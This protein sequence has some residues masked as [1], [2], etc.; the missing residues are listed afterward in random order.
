[1][2]LCVAVVHGGVPRIAQFGNALA[3]GYEGG[4]RRHAAHEPVINPGGAGPREE[5]FEIHAP[6]IPILRERL[7]ARRQRARGGAL[8]RGACGLA[9]AYR[10]VEPGGQI[11]RH[12]KM[13]R[14]MVGHQDRL[15]FLAQALAEG[16][17]IP[18]GMGFRL[19]HAGVDEHAPPPPGRKPHVDVLQGSGD[20]QTNPAQVAG[21]IHGRTDGRDLPG[22]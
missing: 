8:C 12:A 15:K 19:I 1:M 7:C 14:V 22:E 13:I 17:R 20:R 21:D 10:N 18:G 3:L 6:S 16:Q 4:R 11:G 9:H 2:T 5:H